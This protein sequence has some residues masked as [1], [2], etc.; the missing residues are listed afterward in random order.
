MEKTSPL[1]TIN[2]KPHDH[3]DVFVSHNFPQEVF[4]IIKLE[5][6]PATIICR[7]QTDKKIMKQIEVS[8]SRFFVSPQL[9]KFQA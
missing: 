1:N 6:I 3:K 2:S 5:T 8:M 7:D 4:H 9:L